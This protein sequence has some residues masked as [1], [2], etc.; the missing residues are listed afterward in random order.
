M[1]LGSSRGPHV[2]LHCRRERPARPDQGA[3]HLPR[4]QHRAWRHA[5]PGAATRT[6]VGRVHPEPRAALDRL[7]RIPQRRR[8]R[9]RVRPNPPRCSVIRASPRRHRVCEGVISR[10]PRGD[11]RDTDLRD[12]HRANPDCLAPINGTGRSHQDPAR[13][14]W[15][16]R[17]GLICATTHGNRASRSPPWPQFPCVSSAPDRR[18]QVRVTLGLDFG[19]V[20]LHT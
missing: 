2:Y 8:H 13:A 6:R 5:L 11:D 18:S 1:R 12:T 9:S 10:N 20:V 16:I 3:V 7:P 19:S 17:V 14:S 4:N 15:W